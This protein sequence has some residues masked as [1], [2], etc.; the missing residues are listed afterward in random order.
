VLL[1]LLFYQMT[2]AATAAAL[3]GFGGEFVLIDCDSPL[4]DAVA[5]FGL[6]GSCLLF[7]PLIRVPR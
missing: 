3:Q 6:G 7:L 4:V 1:L 5:I 2:Y